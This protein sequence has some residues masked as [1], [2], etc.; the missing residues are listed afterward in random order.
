MAYTF[1]N[2]KPN[3]I[4]VVILLEHQVVGLLAIAKC[5][6]GMNKYQN[7]RTPGTVTQKN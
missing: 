2:R 6:A 5:M 4:N 7:I 1:H 3:R